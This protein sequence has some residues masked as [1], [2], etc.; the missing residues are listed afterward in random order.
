MSL[1]IDLKTSPSPG[2]NCPMKASTLCKYIHDM[3]TTTCT[4]LRSLCP[5]RKEQIKLPTHTPSKDYTSK[6]CYPD[7]PTKTPRVI[8]AYSPWK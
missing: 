1:S 7:S 8:G 3:A 2:N 5:K 6:S 4:A